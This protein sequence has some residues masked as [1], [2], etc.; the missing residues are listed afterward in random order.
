ME[1]SNRNSSITYAFVC[2]SGISRMFVFPFDR[3][4][5]AEKKA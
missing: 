5:E 4:D 1:K 2:I 3:I